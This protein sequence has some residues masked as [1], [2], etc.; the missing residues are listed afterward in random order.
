MKSNMY[1]AAGHAATI[2]MPS[3]KT[4]LNPQMAVTIRELQANS[5]KPASVEA[6]IA[7]YYLRSEQENYKL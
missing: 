7:I 2:E 5:D 1:N 4:V 3:I 6:R